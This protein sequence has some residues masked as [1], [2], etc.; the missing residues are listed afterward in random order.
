MPPIRI[1]YTTRENPDNHSGSP[2]LTS[3]RREPTSINS[4]AI[5]YPIVRFIFMLQLLFVG[6]SSIESSLA[7]RV[8]NSPLNA[9]A[10]REAV[11]LSTRF[12]HA[13]HTACVRWVEGKSANVDLFFTYKT[14]AVITFFNTKQGTPDF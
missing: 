8:T 2:Y 11:S 3:T 1:Q 9:L 4:H 7:F 14:V 5:K 13:F 10:R 12:L 6:D